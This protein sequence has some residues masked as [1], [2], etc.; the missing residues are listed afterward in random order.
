MKVADLA[1]AEG[2]I[3]V[4]VPGGG[5]V[6]VVYRP[7]ILTST[8]VERFE[9]AQE[10]EE[11][12]GLYGELLVSWDIEDEAGEP[13]PIAPEGLGQL[14]LAFMGEIWRSIVRRASPPEERGAPSGRR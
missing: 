12:F 14:P 9:G 7:R 8:F 10:I 11:I 4:P 13:L 5:E 2:K 3:T 6:T 1:E